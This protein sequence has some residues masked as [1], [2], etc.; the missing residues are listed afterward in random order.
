M[1]LEGVGE[2]GSRHFGAREC[3]VSLM[4]GSSRSCS[5]GLVAKGSS[6][7]SVGKEEVARESVVVTSLSPKQKSAYEACKA[8]KAWRSLYWTGFVQRIL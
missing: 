6:I 5:W 2:H 3:R 7:G 4:L 1:L 8:C